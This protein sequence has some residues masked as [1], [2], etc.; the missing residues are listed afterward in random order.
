MFD[1]NRLTAI[2]PC[3]K[4]LNCDGNIHAQAKGR[5]HIIMKNNAGRIRRMRRS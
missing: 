1:A 5:Q 4:S 2:S 3:E